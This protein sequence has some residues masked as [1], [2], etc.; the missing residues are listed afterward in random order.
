MARV[1]I[2][3]GTFNPV[4]VGHLVC[5]QE[6]LAQLGLDRVVLMPAAVPPHK[7]VPDDP[8]VDHRIGMC[9]RAVDGDGR[10]SVS[11]VEADREGTSYTVATLREIRESQP[12]DDLTFIVGGDMAR[13]LPT[14]REPQAVLELAEVAVAQRGDAGRSVVTEALSGLSGAA[15]RVRFFD[16]PRLDVSSTDVRRRAAEGRPIRWLVPDSV[17]RYITDYGLYAAETA[18]S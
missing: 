9:S 6:A 12:G 11:S 18:G 5:A 8:G 16:T 2:L 7:Q 17:L 10:F 1:G 4:H 3:G 15:Q 14:W 13:S